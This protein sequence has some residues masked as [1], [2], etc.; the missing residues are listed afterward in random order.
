MKCKK[1]LAGAL[2]DYFADFRAKRS[3]LLAD[4]TILDAYL[5]DGA[6]RARQQAAETM[7]SVREAMG[8]LKPEI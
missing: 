8:M 5:K 4:K 7:V 3:E 6:D 2:I 1:N